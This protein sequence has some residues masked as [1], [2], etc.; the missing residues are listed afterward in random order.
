MSVLGVSSRRAAVVLAVAVAGSLFFFRLGSPP[1]LVFDEAYYVPD[2][3]DLLGGHIEPQGVHPPLGKWLIAEAIRLG[4]LHA[5][6]WRAPSALAAVA[7]LALA[8]ALAGRF[9]DSLSLRLLPLLLLTDRAFF[10][11]GRT[12]FLDM[13]LACATLLALW[14]GIRAFELSRERPS[15]SAVE[16]LAAYGVAGAAT[17][18][19]WSGAIALLTVAFLHAAAVRESWQRS[20]LSRETLAKWLML[21]LVVAVLVYGL[22]WTA[23]VVDAARGDSESCQSRH[24][25]GGFAA[26]PELLQHHESMF[27]F[28]TELQPR[29]RYAAPVTS[30]FTG[31]R[32]TL[33]FEV[34]C[35]QPVS[36]VCRAGGMTERIVGA[37][38]PVLWCAGLIAAVVLLARLLLRRVDIDARQIAIVAVPVLAVLPWLI[39]GRKVYG[40]NSVI[41]SPLVLL[42]IICFLTS[43]PSRLR[44]VAVLVIVVAAISQS[45]PHLGT[46]GVF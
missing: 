24:C 39:L 37:T 29:N 12:A 4:G 42:T 16:W 13:P 15:S 25:H 3:V 27:R 43:L 32:G 28:E 36:S 1:G 11:A 18:I 21:P 31:R 38:N 30:W 26:I 22:C 2:A 44:T 33:L 20:P 40:F 9:T 7:T 14:L 41:A 8:V 34:G 46:Y 19:K 17:A 45:I 23:W 6:V 5:W 35:G 10:T